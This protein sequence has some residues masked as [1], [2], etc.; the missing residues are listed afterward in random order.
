MKNL[1][2]ILTIAIFSLTSCQKTDEF[3]IDNDPAVTLKKI[4]NNAFDV[5]TIGDEVTV[6]FNGDFVCNAGPTYA[7]WEVAKI[8]SVAQLI[9][10]GYKIEISSYW[11][12]LQLHVTNNQT[13]Y[14]VPHCTFSNTTNTFVSNIASGKINHTNKP[15]AN[16]IYN[17][18]INNG[19]SSS[20]VGVP[21]C[22]TCPH[23]TPKLVLF[24]PVDDIVLFLNW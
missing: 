10:G 7:C 20:G 15:L 16:G 9:K 22:I 12:D 19:C 11:M 3:T 4:T 8:T 24:K 6:H 17:S 18:T 21:N 1:I 14:Q 13:I 23:E 5:P 2:F